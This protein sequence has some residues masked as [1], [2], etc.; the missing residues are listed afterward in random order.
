MW[1]VG[2]NWHFGAEIVLFNFQCTL[3]PI[4]FAACADILLR[5]DLRTP[6]SFA[7][8][9]ME[10][11]RFLIVPMHLSCA[12]SEKIMLSG[13]FA[14]RPHLA[15]TLRRRYLKTHHFL[16][17]FSKA[18]FKPALRF[19]VD[20]TSFECWA[21]RKHGD[22]VTI[23]FPEFFS[24]RN[25]NWLVIEAFFKTASVVWMKNSWCLFRVKPPLLL[26]VQLTG[27][28]SRVVI[29]RRT[30][31]LMSRGSWNLW[32]SQLWLSSI[33][34]MFNRQTLHLYIVSCFRLACT[35]KTIR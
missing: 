31:E 11:C 20:G 23:N 9:I 3:I 32:G 7:H 8:R 26:L 16:R 13:Y 29:R 27:P 22:D 28:W 25:L 2:L 15:S 30:A 10:R 6:E 33:L 19:R 17:S 24:N 21:F 4:K 5:E 1:S 34:C 14:I 18:R 12:S 35:G